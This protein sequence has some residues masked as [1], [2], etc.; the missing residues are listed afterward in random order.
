M[1]AVGAR[2]IVGAGTPEAAWQ[3]WLRAH[4]LPAQSARELA[5]G[6]RTVHVLAPHPDDE[7]LGCAGIM[8]QLAGLGLDV[9]VWAV[10]DGEASHPDSPRYPG[11][12]LAEIRTRESRRALR[13]LGIPARRAR[14]RLPDGGVSANEAA[15]T[16]RL[17]DRLEAGDLVLGTWSLDGHPDHEAVGRAG[18]R[19]ALRARCR[20]FDVPIWGW[21]WAAPERG[22]LP[23][24][25]AC[26]IPLAPDDLQAKRL[27]V[28]RFRSQL[29]PDPDT[30]RPPILPAFALERLLR[31]FEVLLR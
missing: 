28:Q 9:Q 27:A 13:A 6:S 16:E 1:D 20:Y 21:H 24:D 31:P 14:L 10:T 2:R 18:R 22:E 19:A 15:L 17:A 23:A 3:D 26:R 30:G 7:I 8:R 11:D 12:A 4:P 5:G 25:R 29:E